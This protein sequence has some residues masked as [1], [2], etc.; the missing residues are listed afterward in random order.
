M[1]EINFKD[2]PKDY[3][4]MLTRSRNFTEDQITKL[5]R[6][7]LIRLINGKDSS[8]S[9]HV[10]ALKKWLD[11]QII[12]VK[13]NN[14]FGDNLGVYF[15]TPFGYISYEYYLPEGVSAISEYAEDKCRYVED[16]TILSD[17]LI[18]VFKKV[19]I[20]FCHELLP[21]IIKGK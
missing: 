7:F 5:W 20:Q 10:L 18:P 6:G 17:N 13:I 4:F 11:Y 3:Q 16:I 21:F 2:V 1:N 15:Q 9:N 8:L 19:A 12:N 14:L